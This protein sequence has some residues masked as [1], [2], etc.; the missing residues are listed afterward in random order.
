[1]NSLWRTFYPKYTTYG[2]DGKGRD[3]YVLKNNGGL[4]VQPE[5]A[6]AQ[7]TFFKQFDQ[8]RSPSPQ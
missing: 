8:Q 3:S 2:S 5:K 1:M 4:C 6:H 7:S